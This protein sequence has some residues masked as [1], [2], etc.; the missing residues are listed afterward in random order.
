MK[1]KI[2]THISY[3]LLLF[4]IYLPFVFVATFLTMKDL[5]NI[6]ALKITG[7]SFAWLHFLGGVL[8]FNR[9]CPILIFDKNKKTISRRGFFFGFKYSIRVD[10]ILF[11]SK[12]V[13]Q[14]D[15]TYYVLVDG[16]HNG[17]YSYS[18]MAPIRIPFSEKGMRFIKLFYDGQLPPG[19]L[20]E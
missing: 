20:K 15:G 1:A 5:K 8:M 11:V 12:A 10:E 7:M 18:K 16:K 4:L 3:F 17:F 19:A 2:F 9:M 14:I 6:D 13:L